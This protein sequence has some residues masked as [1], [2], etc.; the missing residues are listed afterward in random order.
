MFEYTQGNHFKFGYNYKDW[1]CNRTSE[2][3]K[4]V[5]SYGRAS[6]D[7]TSWR[8]AN[9]YAAK[10]IHRAVQGKKIWVLLSGGI[11]SEICLKSFL[12]AQIPVEIAI[13]KYESDS[14]IHDIDYALRFCKARNLSYKIF[15]LNVSKFWGSKEMYEIVDLCHCVSP[16]LAAC[17]WLGDQVD[18]VPVIA[19]GDPY[20][21][22]EI[23]M[24]YVPGES[25]YLPSPWSYVESDRLCSLFRYFMYKQKPAVPAFFQYVPEQILTFLKH[26]RY[27]QELINNRIV[28]KLGTR[29]SKFQMYQEEYPELEIRPKFHGFE[30]FETLHSQY[31][32]ELAERF[33]LADEDF[34]IRYNDM[35]KLLSPIEEQ[36]HEV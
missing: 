1:Y 24:D 3:Q 26:N 7:F 29:T 10:E 36:C 32:T 30:S 35:V 8:Q 20:L 34:L 19:Q 12:E 28:G 17:L 22:K 13:L 9:I 14:N 16:Q 4:F 2:D 15:D 27:L 21:K 11:D 31:R 25:P 18:G 23:S 6:Q 33:P 5:T